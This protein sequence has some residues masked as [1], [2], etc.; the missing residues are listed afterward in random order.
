M[1]S[2][3][4]WKDRGGS[5]W[6]SKMVIGGLRA[7]QGIASQY[8]RGC[9]SWNVRLLSYACFLA[10]IF[11]TILTFLLGGDPQVRGRNNSPYMMSSGPRKGI[12]AEMQDIC[13]N[14]LWADQNYTS[15]LKWFLWNSICF[16][17]MVLSKKLL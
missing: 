13:R 4:W 7:W 17:N 5:R 6:E 8:W 1:N 11:I 10:S 16:V 14:T 2:V 15:H 12:I 3:R 9:F